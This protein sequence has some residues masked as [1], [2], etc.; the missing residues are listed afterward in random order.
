MR[1]LRDG[2]ESA[3]SAGMSDVQGK[4]AGGGAICAPDEEAG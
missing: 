2:K 1:K 4:T 3:R